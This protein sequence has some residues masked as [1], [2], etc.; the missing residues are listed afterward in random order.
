[1]SLFEK[2][3]RLGPSDAED[4]L[5]EIMAHVLSGSSELG[6]GWLRHTGCTTITNCAGWPLP[7]CKDIVATPKFC[8]LL[9]TAPPPVKTPL[10]RERK[11]G[12][13]WSNDSS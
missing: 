6:L 8:D 1:M 12:A 5:T 9:T 2:L 7:P 11:C 13:R 3:I 10:Q 4:Y